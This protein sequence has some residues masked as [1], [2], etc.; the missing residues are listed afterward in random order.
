MKVLL[1]GEYS[2][3]HW[4]LAEG[5]RT[6]GHEVVVASDGDGFKNHLRNIDLI[7]R[8]SGIIDTANTLK[9]IYTNL[10]NFKGFDVVQLINP[11]FTPMNV[12]I[13][14]ILYRYLRKHN[15]KI[16]LG[17]FGDDS[18]WLK[19][20]LNGETFRY[21]E[22]YGGSPKS[23]LKENERLKYLWGEGTQRENLN[24]E[25]ADT[26]DGIIACLYE[27]YKSYQPFYSEKLTYI[28]LPFNL[29]KIKSIEHAYISDKI[30]FFI[31]I[32]KARSKFKGTDRLYNVLKEIIKKYPNEAAIKTVESIEYKR[33]IDEI[34]SSD[35]V[36]DQ[37]YSYSPAMNGL[38]ALAMG[39]VLVG[40][41]EPE[42]YDLLPDK[43][44]RPIVNVLPSEEDIFNKLENLV[45]NKQDIPQMADNGRKFVEEHHNHIKVAR[46]YLEFWKK[47]N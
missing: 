23:V 14:G 40:G 35:V 13:N 44:N 10:N 9:S 34:E 6:L 19:A 29:N 22:F 4:T 16:F 25:I 33:Y 43:Y 36:L 37:L 38:L 11:C 24:K 3:L 27:Y 31:G 32:N 15:K 8:S 1:L 20:C 28:P 45:I 7:R 26:C 30:N 5:L 39:K 2:N 47:N 18:Y 46:Q 21:C 42:M 41:G 17:A 12:K